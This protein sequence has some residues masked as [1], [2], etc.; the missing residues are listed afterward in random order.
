[1]RE[2]ERER[3][4]GYTALDTD[5]CTRL[6]Q[7]EQKVNLIEHVTAEACGAQSFDKHARNLS[8]MFALQISPKLAYLKPKLLQSEVRQIIMVN[9]ICVEGNPVES[10][11]IYLQD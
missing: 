6:Y 7:M 2:R 1:M 9:L 5:A 10:L 3:A 11:G 8:S 4:S